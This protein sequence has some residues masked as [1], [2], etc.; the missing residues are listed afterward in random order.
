MNN[1]AQIHVLEVIVVAGM[2]LTS[3]FFVRTFEFTPN[4]T[5]T[6]ENELEILGDGI[7]ANLESV[8]DNLGQYPSLL[9]RYISD[10]ESIFPYVFEFS[11]YVNASLPDGTI[12]EISRIDITKYSTYPDRSI[13]DPTITETPYVA[14][15]KVGR[16]AISS[17]IVVIEGNVYEVTLTMYFTL[18]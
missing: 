4:I 1:S 8:P 15:V 14:K 12:Y 16:E 11:E 7:L 13:K 5:T 10:S 6:E 9:A 18:R 17:R 2:L 3:L